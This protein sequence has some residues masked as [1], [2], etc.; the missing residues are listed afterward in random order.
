[1]FFGYC[2]KKNKSKFFII[3]IESLMEVCIILYILFSVLMLYFSWK[4]LSIFINHDIPHHFAYGFIPQYAI[5]IL[6]FHATIDS[7]A[8]QCAIYC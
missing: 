2:A 8:S 7:A 5:T 1:M 3:Q 4:Q 6:I